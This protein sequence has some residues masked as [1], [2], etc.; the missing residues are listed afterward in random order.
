VGIEDIYAGDYIRRWSRFGAV[1]RYGT[2]R[3]EDIIMAICS[4]H[5][6]LPSAACRN[7]RCPRLGALQRAISFNSAN[8]L[9]HCTEKGCDSDLQGG[10]DRMLGTR[11]T[12]LMKKDHAGRYLPIPRS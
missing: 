10:A 5:R 11:P 3:R 1:G 7:R 4:L 6:Q 12:R 8:C 2:A 9:E